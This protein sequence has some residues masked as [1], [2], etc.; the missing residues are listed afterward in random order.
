MSVDIRKQFQK[1]LANSLNTGQINYLGA[2]MDRG[3]DLFHESGFSSRMPIPQQTAA[4][5]LIRYFNSI[6]EIVGLFTILL[7]HEGKR[8]YNTT[9]KIVGGD[10]FINALR[11]NKWIYDPEIVRFFMDPFYEHAINFLQNLRVIDLRGEVPVKSIIRGITDVSKTMGIQDLEWRI[12][13]R[14]YD[15]DPQSSE[16]IRKIISLLLVRQKLEK[17]TSELF[18]CLKELAINASKANYKVLYGKQFSRM[19]PSGNYLDF[20]NSFKEEIEENGNRRLLELA[21]QEDRFIN[22]TFQSTLEA[23][24]MWVTNSGNISAIEKEQILKKLG[25]GELKN[26]NMTKKGI[27]DEGAGMGLNLILSV[28]KKYSRDGSPLKVIFYPG[29]IKMGFSIERSELEPHLKQ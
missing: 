4:D 19:T 18:V 8:F 20:L 26:R 13:L 21:K 6:E 15:L 23:I 5:I 12:T 17:F 1:L 24:E 29:H 14:L 10:D 2:Q 9:L 28:L 25:E 7:E 3:F 22:I 16:L 11:H 27:Y